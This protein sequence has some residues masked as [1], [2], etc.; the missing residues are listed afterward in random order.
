MSVA[1]HGGVDLNIED[2]HKHGHK[3][4]LLVNLQPAGEYL[5][6]DF[7]HAGGVP[8]VVNELM[9]QGLIREGAPT[10]NGKSIGENCRAT[11]IQDDK[12]IRHFDNPLKAEAG[13]LV[14]RGNLFDN[15]IMKTSVISSAFP[16]RS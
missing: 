3:V 4:P 16:A 5:G 1:R 10:V 11:T 9:G 2:G 6:E 13:F 8:A 12:V 7:Y 14:L 15:A